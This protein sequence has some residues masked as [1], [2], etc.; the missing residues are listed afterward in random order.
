[1]KK[2]MFLMA[3]GLVGI[4]HAAPVTI[5]NPSFEYPPLANG[6]YTTN[7]T[8]TGWTKE[9][10]SWI[11][12]PVGET[13]G[14]LVSDGN[15]ALINFQQGVGVYQ[16]GIGSVVANAHYTFEVDI[17]AG[18]GGAPG[19][20]GGNWVGI[21]VGTGG[22]LIV[23]ANLTYGSGG[24]LEL[25]YDPNGDIIN[26]SNTSPEGT[27]FT[28]FSD[29]NIEYGQW[30]T[31]RLEWDVKAGS[32][33]SGPITIYL[34]RSSPGNSNWTMFDNVRMD[35]TP[36]FNYYYRLGED[37]PGATAGNPTTNPT[38]AAEGGIHLQK[39]MNPNSFIYSSDVPA[40]TTSG[41][42]LSIDFSVKPV[43]D[44]F[45]T[46]HSG[47]APP[48]DN[49]VFQ[50]WFKAK[51]TTGSKNLA[52]FG[53]FYGSNTAA[54]GKAAT[55]YGFYQ[56]QDRYAAAFANIG[57]RD[58]GPAVV[59]QWTH[60]AIV[61]D[62]AAFTGDS[63]GIRLYVNGVQVAMNPLGTPPTPPF[64]LMTMGAT[65]D[66]DN[67]LPGPAIIEMNNGLV[68]DVRFST[69]AS[70]SF[71]P[72]LLMIPLLDHMWNIDADGFWHIPSNWTGG[73]VP[74]GIGDFANMAGI[75]TAPRTITNNSAITLGSL[76]F[77]NSNKYTI[78]G[79]GSITLNDSGTAGKINCT[80]GT[81]EIAQEI[82]GTHGLEKSGS[83]TLL[84]SYPN[85]SYSGTTTIKG[86]V[87]EIK[88]AQSLGPT[89]DSNPVIV[90]SGGQLAF[91]INSVIDYHGKPLVINGQGPNGTGALA[92]SANQN[93]DVGWQNITIA[94]DSVINVSSDTYK[95]MSFGDIRGSG[96]IYKIGNQR[97]DF[98]MPNPEGVTP[99][100]GEIIV[101]EGVFSI[102][103]F[104]NSLGNAKSLTIQNSE[105][106]LAY[107]IWSVP[108][109]CDI[110]YVPTPLILKAGH[111][112]L[113]NASGRPQS[114][115]WTGTV[116]ITKFG[117]TIWTKNPD[118]TL[119]ISG[120]IS[121]SGL[122]TVVG[123]GTVNLVAD[124]DQFIGNT[125]IRTSG[126]LRLS[127]SGSLSHSPNIVVD[128]YGILQIT[129]TGNVLSDVAVVDIRSTGKI[130]LGTGVNEKVANLILAGVVQPAGTYG[131]TSSSATYKDD[132]Y[133]A[134][135]GILTVT[136]SSQTTLSGTVQLGDWI[137]TNLDGMTITVEFKNGS[138]TTTV[139]TNVN[140]N[141]VFEVGTPGPGTYDI[142]VKA[143]HWLAKKHTGV[144]II[145]GANTDPVVYDLTNGDANGDN[146][147]N[148]KDFAVVAGSWYMAADATSAAN[149]NGDSEVNFQDLLILAT[150]W[151]KSG[152]ML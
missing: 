102:R 121:G 91:G 6:S 139:I 56:L 53:D 135:D 76:L 127:G 122:L 13:P 23:S 33:L 62:T 35:I 149:L 146:S 103:H 48:A 38:R 15:N 95:A 3:L 9:G 94:T 107:D 37:D 49:W 31:L 40:N 148:L 21:R 141:G 151:L 34:R 65:R 137:P 77:S 51:D 5:V 78:S 96:K 115:T 98:E 133:F 30:H 143:P 8:G 126:T 87:L 36:R 93:A 92:F 42:T 86:G 80:V 106:L 130:N 10:T 26:L 140:N 55:G 129:N 89:G 136:S 83:G 41:S 144:V 73:I 104:P 119:N 29:S 2:V 7:F 152:D 150:E 84:L 59:G 112:E 47:Y 52:F 147:V 17:Y 11:Y 22:P 16:T 71:S 132:T 85:N 88:Y 46:V 101:L 90:E 120:K 39:V 72:S 116:E 134:G 20:Y 125:K 66:L 18:G 123:P 145:S 4:V 79:S 19:V 82:K 54:T 63:Q 75:I 108:D 69:F 64:G 1:M 45:F 138:T 50:G 131:S 67:E 61:R 60:L 14:G 114:P 117:G 109:A 142:R 43:D 25:H 111:F 28:N 110:V 57:F 68:D 97:L 105:F 113:D 128:D 70:G 124:N 12:N 81:H 58:M 44:M 27:G 24:S 99:Y 32:T 74:N 118:D 100:N